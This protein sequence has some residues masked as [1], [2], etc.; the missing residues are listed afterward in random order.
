MTTDN[1][2]IYKT[3]KSKPIKTGGQRYSDTSPFSIPALTL[4]LKIR[5]QLI[6]HSAA[7]TGNKQQVTKYE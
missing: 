6:Y 3:G 4:D 5:S 7:V 2:F 1:F